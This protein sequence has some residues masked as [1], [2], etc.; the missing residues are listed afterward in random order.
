MINVG[1]GIVMAASSPFGVSTDGREYLPLVLVM[2]VAA[3]TVWLWYK[4]KGKAS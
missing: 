1:G 4:I 2:I 3:V